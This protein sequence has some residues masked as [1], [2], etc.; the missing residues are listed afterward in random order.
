[1][2]SLLKQLI[3]A[4]ILLWPCLVVAADYNPATTIHCAAPGTLQ[5]TNEAIIAT[6]LKVTGDIDARDFKTLKKVTINTTQVLDLSEATI[7]AYKGADGSYLELMSDWFIQDPSN[8]EYP[9]NTLPTDAFSEERD[10]SLSKWRQVSESLRKVILPR[11][12][13]GAMQRSLDNGEFLTEIIVPAG[14]TSLWS[15]GNVIYD[16]ARTRLIGIAGGFRGE[17]TLPA[18]LTSVDAGVFQRVSPTSITFLCDKMPTF[19]A[20]NNKLQCAY[21]VAPNADK[22]KE[23]FPDIDCT[24]PFDYVEVSNVSAGNLKNSLAD[25]GMNRGDLRALK[26]AGTIE[27]S[28]FDWLMELPNLH[29]LDLSGLVGLDFWD[30]TYIYSKALTSLQLP[31]SLRGYIIIKAPYLSGDLNVSKG[32]Y[33]FACSDS[34][35]RK[36]VFPASLQTFSQESF[37]NQSIEEADFSQCANLPVIKGFSNCMSLRKLMLPNNLKE[38]SVSGPLQEVELPLS[39]C[40]LEVLGGRL[41]NLCSRYR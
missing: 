14:N 17:L 40:K 30:D 7:H 16:I 20:D 35:I 8:V 27:K 41:R 38:L 10:N 9:A 19:G 21:I 3:V 2:K 31:D 33:A 1:M 22:Y 34:R 29:K 37:D 32:V 15:D 4:L 39:L 5:L 26:I 36:V 25:L 24:S 11:T 23:L 13:V 28:E 18:T 6:N 12:M